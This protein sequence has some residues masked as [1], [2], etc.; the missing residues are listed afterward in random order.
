MDWASLLGVALGGLIATA[1]SVVIQ[2]MQGHRE[3]RRQVGEMAVSLA[4]AERKQHIAY[5]ES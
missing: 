2:V 5:V 4:Q 3:D 1:A